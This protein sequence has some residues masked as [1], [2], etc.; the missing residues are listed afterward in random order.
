MSLDGRS[1][2]V[3]MRGVHGRATRE[4]GYFGVFPNL[5]VSTPPDY[6][7]THRLEPIG[8]DRTFVECE[9]LFPPEALEL[10]GF[11][12]GYAVEF[13]DVTNAEDWSAVESLQRAA[14]SRG[15]RPGPLS[16]VWE[17]GVYLWVRMIAQ[18]YL[19]GGV[20]EPP[21]LPEIGRLRRRES[22]HGAAAT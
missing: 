19:D 6:L 1:G 4:V 7:L 18:G 20:I 15:H 3:R 8:P 16:P 5:F 11:D 22:L 9:W 10:P 14:A 17:A 2:G 21:A 12:P 13:W